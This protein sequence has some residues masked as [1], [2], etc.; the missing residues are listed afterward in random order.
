MPAVP[1][2]EV[3]KFEIRV[4]MQATVFAYPEQE[5]APGATALAKPG[6]VPIALPVWFAKLKV[7]PLTKVLFPSSPKIELYSI[8]SLA[9]PDAT[10]AP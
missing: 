9:S 2:P 3:L 1:A 5:G 7:P 8:R 6:L 4:A 10:L